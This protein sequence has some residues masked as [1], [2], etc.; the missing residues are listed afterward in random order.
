MTSDRIV[1]VGLLTQRDV[2]LLGQGFS[3]LFPV[4]DDVDFADLLRQ[5]DG[6]AAIPAHGAANAS[7]KHQ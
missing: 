7:P 3:R 5:L 6:V 4:T 2:S 1:A